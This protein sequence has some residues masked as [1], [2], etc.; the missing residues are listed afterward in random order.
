MEEITLEY[1]GKD[2]FVLFEPQVAYDAFEQ[3]YYY[4]EIKEVYVLDD[5]GN[6]KLIELDYNETN[7]LEDIITDLYNDIIAERYYND[8]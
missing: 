1:N 6:D 5:K 2:L 8:Y 7:E 4:P 3:A